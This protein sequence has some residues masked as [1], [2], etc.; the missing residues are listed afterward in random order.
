MKSV[1]ASLNAK[2][3]L[4]ISAV[5]ICVFGIIAVLGAQSQRTAMVDQMETSVARTAEL[6]RQAIEKPMV[7]GNDEGTKEEFA[8][9]KERYGDVT[10]YLTNFKGDITYS[11]HGEAV[12]KIFN[13]VQTH[14]A[15]QEFA[16]K[17]LAQKMEA[18]QIFEIGSTTYFTEIMSIPNAPACYHCHGKNQPILGEMIV[19][20]D[21]SPLM[22]GINSQVRRSALISA[23]GLAVLLGATLYF[24]RRAVVRRIAVLASAS[25]KVTGGDYNVSFDVGGADELFTLAGNLGTMVGELKNK[26]GFAGGILK[27]MTMPC[28]VM[29]KDR[30]LTFINQVMLDLIKDKRRPEDCIGILLEDFLRDLRTGGSQQM[31]ISERCIAERKSF[32]GVERD[33]KTRTGEAISLRIDTAPLFDL[34]GE[35]LGAFTIYTDLTAIKAD[36]ARIA[37]QNK[38]ITAVAAKADGIAQDMADS[39]GRLSMQVDGAHQGS[40]RQTMRLA[41]TAT[42]MDEMNATV[43]EVARNAGRASDSAGQTKTRAQGGVKIVEDAVAAILRVQTEAEAMREKMRRLGDVAEGVGR[44]MQ[45]I[46]DIA[47]QTNLLALNAAIEAAR[48]GDAGRG[49]AVVADEVR[50]LAERTMEATKEVAQAIGSIQTG[51]AEN[52]AAT[53]NAT[54]A[55]N[56]SAEMAGRSGES[57]RE[58]LILA[59]KTADEV[60]AIATA[61]EQQSATS[62]EINRSVDEINGI[63]ADT[64]QTM[65]EAAQA[66]N[67]VARLASELKELIATMR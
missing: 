3:A 10:V 18:G 12:R 13:T 66:V 24:M 38:T 55:V 26:L 20:Q 34:D 19:M 31:G 51:V 48:A 2:I 23:L 46:E 8:Q 56:Q 27:G 61:A 21:V 52:V 50:K 57:L 58:I 11:T 53:E 4:L 40:E 49:F 1:S 65:N 9:V 36:Q 63:A 33:M 15:L 43:L 62:E 44:I 28:M 54:E 42:A 41:E 30:H 47:D 32:I 7:V 37:E 14:T 67:H 17:G 16:A 39:S 29:D 35:L 60:R 64:S 45:V 22:A 59:D 6:I 25:D 5:A